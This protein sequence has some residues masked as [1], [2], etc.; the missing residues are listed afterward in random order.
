MKKIKNVLLVLMPILLGSLV[1]FCVKDDFS[2]LNT[3]PHNINLPGFIFVIAWSIIYL[4]SG[5][6]SYLYNRKGGNLTIYFLSLAL[7][8][9][10]TP[11]LF[12]FH[13][14]IAS[15]ILVITLLLI[16][17]FMFLKDKGKTKLLLL[18]YVLWLL[19]A[20][21]LMVDLTLCNV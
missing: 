8:L 9:L 20:L 16:V 7:N 3:I 6:W 17:F 21:T 18:P 5:I 10:F 2:Y 14:I 13:Q 11:L 1:G 4:L 19:V 15:L 12:S